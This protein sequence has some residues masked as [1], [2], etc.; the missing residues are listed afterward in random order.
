MACLTGPDTALQ[1]KSESQT[2]AA[3]VEGKPQCSAGMQPLK[4]QELRKSRLDEAHPEFYDEAAQEIFLK[5]AS[6]LLEAR[7]SSHTRSQSAAARLSRIP[8]CAAN[9]PYQ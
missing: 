1:R 8:R 2:L 9:G 6:A 4:L 7:R 5:T 3:G